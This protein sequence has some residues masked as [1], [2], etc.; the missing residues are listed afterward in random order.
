MNGSKYTFGD[1]QASINLIDDILA[2]PEYVKNRSK[3]FRL[4]G[5]QLQAFA[6]IVTIPD[7]KVRQATLGMWHDRFALRAAELP[8]IVRT[9]TICVETGHYRERLREG[10]L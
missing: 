4:L 1:S 3:V 8:E 2:K 10:K 9:H 7:R 5:T 6:V